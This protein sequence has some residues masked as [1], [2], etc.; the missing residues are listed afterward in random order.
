LIGF[1]H[2]MLTLI[3]QFGIRTAPTVTIAVVCDIT[4]YILIGRQ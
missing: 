1:I 2:R 4:Q 3:V